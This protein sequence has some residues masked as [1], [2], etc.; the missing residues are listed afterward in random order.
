MVKR[1]DDEPND[2]AHE[3]LRQMEDARRPVPDKEQEQKDEKQQKH[4][5]PDADSPS[6]PQKNPPK[7]S[8]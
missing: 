2:K 4:I 8:S 7:S 1:S 5:P 3:R 6:S